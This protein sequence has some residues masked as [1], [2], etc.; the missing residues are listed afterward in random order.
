MTKNIL[1]IMLH[2][3]WVE[4]PIT[5]RRHVGEGAFETRPDGTIGMDPGPVQQ[6]MAVCERKGCD[7]KAWDYV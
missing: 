6:L 7:A 3:K 1:C 4:P 2:H 5:V